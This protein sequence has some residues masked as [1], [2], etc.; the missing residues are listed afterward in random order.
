MR[1]T[2]AVIALALLPVLGTAHAGAWTL[3][4]GKVSLFTG[5]TA[6]TA[7]RR[8]DDGGSAAKKTIFRKILFQNWTEVGLT[9]AVTLFAAPEYVLAKSGAQTSGV[10]SVNSMS[11]E[12]GLRILLLSRIGML[13]VQGSAKSAGAFDMSTSSSGESGRQ[14]EARLLYGRN[15]KFLDRYGFF[16]IEAAERWITRPRPD[17]FVFDAAVGWWLTPEYL[18]L[19]QSF[20]FITASDATPPYE[21]YRLHKLQF[22]LVSP[23]TKRWSIQSGYFFSIAGRNIVKESGVVTTIWY[24][25]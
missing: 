7:A 24:K 8:F 6:S 16:D 1:R 5:M 12:G 20:N 4:S 13:S 14:F 22:S 11:V 23:V 10:S 9:D 15:F 21:P 17:E 18:V 19:V 3:D 2:A 25:T